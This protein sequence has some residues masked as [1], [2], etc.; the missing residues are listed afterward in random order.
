[1]VQ[2][3]H[4]SSHVEVTTHYAA[5]TIHHTHVL[6]SLLLASG[7]AGNNADR[8]WVCVCDV[9]G[10]E[11]LYAVCVCSSASKSLFPCEAADLLTVTQN[12]RNYHTDIYVRVRFLLFCT[13][14]RLSRTDSRVEHVSMLLEQT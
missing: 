13:V 3:L 8:S 14:P 9:R 5:I 6:V 11:E 2:H 1:M 12:S 10:L 7:R 4:F